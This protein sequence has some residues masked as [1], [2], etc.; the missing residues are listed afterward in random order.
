MLPPC[1]AFFEQVGNDVQLIR[2]LRAAED[3]D[4]RTDGVFEGIRHDGEFFFDEEAADGG[5]HQPVFH[6]R[7]RGSVR[8]V[9]GAECVVHV[10]VAVRGEFFAEFEVFL[11]L[12]PVE[13]EV[14][15]QNAF[16]FFA[17]GDFLLRV[18]SHDVRR[19]RHLVSEQ[20]VQALRNGGE[21]EFF[22]LVLFRFFDDRF[23]GRLAGVYL[24]LVFLVEF[25]FVGEDGVGFAHVRAEGDFRAAFH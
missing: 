23:R 9:R 13:T 21:G 18:R 16:A 24:F 8:A 1:V 2:D 7:R 25:H 19:K 6:D 22:R 14:F 5:F 20:F 15:E 11:F 3:R 17:G 12:F 10:G 4:E